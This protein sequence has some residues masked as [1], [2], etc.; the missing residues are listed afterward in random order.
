MGT[1]FN[2]FVD[3][4]TGVISGAGETTQNDFFAA[5]SLN[6]R[7]ES[8]I[9]VA[10]IFVQDQI[11]INQYLDIV[12]GARFDSFDQTTVNLVDPANPVSGSRTDEKVSPRFGAIYKP[13]DNIS[14]YAS[15]SEAFL[16][17]S[18]EQFASTGSLDPDEYEQAEIGVKWDFTPGMSFTAAY[19][20]NDQTTSARN[21]V[22]EEEFEE[23]GLEVEGLEL[24]FQGQVTEQ[25]YL[26]AGYSY[27]EGETDDGA[28]LPRELPEHTFSIWGAYQVT[29]RLG[30]GLGATHQDETFITDFDIGST[31][32][33]PTLPSYTRVDAAV[34]YDL[35]E[36]LRL[37]LNVENLTDETYFPSSHS[38]HQVTVGAPLNA[39]IAI[40][41]RF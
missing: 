32:P 1:G 14:V 6:D 30:F 13:M 10:S 20:Q 8:E 35:S 25:L 4:V 18:G 26:T 31:G 38:T 24:Q 39:R 15:Y 37:Q 7:N 17:S 2:N 22:T 23:R 19:F 27:L 36:D 41:G 3:P 21:P 16:P 5:G 33:H 40:S 28:E 29:D 9:E 11:E 12:L 34:Y